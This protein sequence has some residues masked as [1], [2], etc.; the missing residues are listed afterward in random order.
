MT[1]TVARESRAPL[2]LVALAVLAAAAAVLLALWDRIPPRWVTHWGPDGIPDAWARRTARGVFLPLGLGALVCLF[3][4]A[5]ALA[6]PRLGRHRASASAPVVAALLSG[7]LRRVEVGLAIVFAALSVALPLLRPRAPGPLAAA[8]IGITA[9]TLYYAV[10][11]L[12]R[13]TRDLRAA[14]HLTGLEGWNGFVY[15]NPA[16]PRLF[17]PNPL[18]LGQT[19]NF[20]HR[21]AYALL[22]LLLLPAIAL[23]T[24]LLWWGRS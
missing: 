24:L 13:A 10:L 23:L 4:E 21:R 18:G 17:V 8:V 2:R 6:A 5:I 11:R 3:L 14:G 9:A 16:D 1:R 7:F 19:L 22:A 12:V 15:R 20:A